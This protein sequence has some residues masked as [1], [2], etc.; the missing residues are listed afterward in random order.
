MGQIHF[1]KVLGSFIFLSSPKQSIISR[2]KMLSIQACVPETLTP[3]PQQLTSYNLPP[4]VT[5]LTQ[6]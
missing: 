2:C 1:T 4:G 6:R 5:Y 3:Q